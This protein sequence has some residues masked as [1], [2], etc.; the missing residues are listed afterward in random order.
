MPDCSFLGE[1]KELTILVQHRES[2]LPEAGPGII[3]DLVVLIP[4][5]LP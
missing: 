2:E 4:V 1:H 5:G 3:K